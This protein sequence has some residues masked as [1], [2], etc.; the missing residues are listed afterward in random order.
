MP[1]VN[2][3]IILVITSKWLIAGFGGVVDDVFIIVL[4]TLPGKNVRHRDPINVARK[5]SNDA[6]STGSWLCDADYSNKNSFFYFKKLTR[7]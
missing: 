6:W 2:E 5:V 7:H 4:S 3:S 1:K